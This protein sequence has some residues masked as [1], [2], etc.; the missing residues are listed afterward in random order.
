MG[1]L[2][3]KDEI[4]ELMRRY[5]QAIDFPDP[6]AWVDCFTDDAVVEITGRPPLNGKEELRAYAEQRPGGSLHLAASEIIDV[7]GDTAHVSS[8]IAVVSAASGT[9]AIMVAGKYE[10]DL[11]RVDGA[12]KFSHRNLEMTIRPG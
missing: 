10:D 1:V 11:R 6:A 7:D 9:P 4:R 3:D 2:E 5:N 12:W 8:Y